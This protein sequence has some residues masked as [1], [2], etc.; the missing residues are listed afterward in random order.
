MF[1]WLDMES[2]CHG[3]WLVDSAY[4]R[5]Y[6]VHEKTFF[7]YFK[8]TYN[9]HVVAHDVGC[10]YEEVSVAEELV[11]PRHVR[12][13]VRVVWYRVELSRKVQGVA[14]CPSLEGTITVVV[15]CCH[16]KAQT[17][18]GCGNGSGVLWLCVCARNSMLT[19]EVCSKQSLSHRSDVYL[20]RIISE[21]TTYIVF[22]L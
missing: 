15:H 4:A 12:H 9:V 13:G 2:N 18:S 11:P 3:R 10:S 19:P 17:G 22:A 16:E 7:T 6:F 5:S 21:V 8:D 20:A 1:A 14:A